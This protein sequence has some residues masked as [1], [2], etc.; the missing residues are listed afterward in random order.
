VARERAGERYRLLETIKQYAQER[1]DATGD[2][3]ATR[4]R[5]LEYFLTLAER[6]RPELIGPEQAT[7]LAKL[8]LE[9]EN[10]LAAHG[11]AGH[12]TQ[13]GQLGLR[14]ASSL[15]RYWII[16]GL[17]TMGHRMAVDALARPDA[18]GHDYARCQ[19]LF[20]AGQ[21]CLWMGRYR[22]AQQHLE[23]SITIARE[24][25]DRRSIALALQPL[26]MV[27]HGLGEFE[28]ARTHMEEALAMAREFG[29]RREIAAALIGLA[30]QH[31]FDGNLSLAEPLYREA[32]DV[33]RELQDREVI[34]VALLNLAM[35]SIGN[36]PQ[37][38]EAMLLEALG[39]AEEIGSRQLA[40]SAL[41]VA[42]GL[43]ASVEEW[44]QAARLY[45][46]A[47][48]LAQQTSLQRDRTDEAFLL[49]L[50]ANARRALGNAAFESTFAAGEALSYATA[51]GELRD[52]LQR[53]TPPA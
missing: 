35:V 4:T 8:D 12:A 44:Y 20:D 28:L 50:V 47:E 2:G 41:D 29:N 27:H 39:I 31:R 25:G 7:W 52:W 33:G 11:W 15:R 1:L 17:P 30:Q 14:L 19:G 16:R 18:Q 21:L 42:A 40:Q 36:A 53:R 48:T 13:G 23:E 43:A 34:C 5:H 46:T 51:M 3:D 22:E 38:V 32:L 49:P 10:L 24:I 37:G 9:R 6:A 45:G 26:G